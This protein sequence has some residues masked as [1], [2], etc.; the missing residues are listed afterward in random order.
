MSWGESVY[1]IHR[2]LGLYPYP[3]G[4]GRIPRLERI[5]ARVA[6]SGTISSSSCGH[7]IAD[8]RTTSSSV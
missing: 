7:V 6:A 3:D 2:R 8:R 4:G 1:K 5:A